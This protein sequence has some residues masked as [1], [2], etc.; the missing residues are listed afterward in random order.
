MEKKSWG[1]VF[2]CDNCSKIIIFTM[3]E[4]MVKM[5]ELAETAKLT[6]WIRGKPISTFIADWKPFIDFFF[7]NS[8]T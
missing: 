4:W 7:R 3:E 6:S 8:K 5:L 1:V 2:V